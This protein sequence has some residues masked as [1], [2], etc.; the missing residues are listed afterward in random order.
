M[1][2]KRLLILATVLVA[3]AVGI[4]VTVRFP[5]VLPRTDFRARY[6][7]VRKGMTVKQVDAIMWGPRDR[8]LPEIGGAGTGHYGNGDAGQEATFHFGDDGRLDAKSFK[9]DW[10]P[11]WLEWF[12]QGLGY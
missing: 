3:V 5:Y 12:R 4:W 7:Q 8:P 11:S 10:E 2:R 6:D 1:T 9:G